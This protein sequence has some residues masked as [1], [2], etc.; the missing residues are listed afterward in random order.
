MAKLATVVAGV[1]SCRL[2]VASGAVVGASTR[3]TLSTSSRLGLSTSTRLARL[4][5]LAAA[6]EGENSPFFPSP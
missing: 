1:V 6:V 3:A 5:A 2:L 4:A